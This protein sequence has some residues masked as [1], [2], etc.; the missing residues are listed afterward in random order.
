MTEDRAKLIKMVR[1]TL[2]RS[3]EADLGNK[4]RQTGPDGQTLRFHLSPVV[5]GA[6]ACVQSDRKNTFTRRIS[7]YNK[8]SPVLETGSS[9]ER[10]KHLGNVFISNLK[11]LDVGLIYK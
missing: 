9:K 7:F 3:E 1:D 6:L 5:G 10:C 2:M 11:M 8:L 4:Q